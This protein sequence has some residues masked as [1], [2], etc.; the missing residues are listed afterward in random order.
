MAEKGALLIPSTGRN[1]LRFFDVG[2]SVLGGTRHLTELKLDL[3]EAN[4][5]LTHWCRKRRGIAVCGL[6]R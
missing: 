3:K 4:R 6:Y 2:H 1:L 5:L